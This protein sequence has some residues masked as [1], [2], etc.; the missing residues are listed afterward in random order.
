MYLKLNKT[1]TNT[2]KYQSS[3]THKHTFTD[4]FLN[5][6]YKWH[7]NTFSCIQHH[8]LSTCI[9]V[10]CTYIIMWNKIKTREDDKTN[11]KKCS[12][13]GT[14]APTSACMIWKSRELSLIYSTFTQIHRLAH[15]HFI[16]V[17]IFS[18][19]QFFLDNA[20]LLAQLMQQL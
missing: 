19:Q 3:H 14:N 7:T 10:I 11:V 13:N 5:A 8:R 9:C 18:E 12:L 16:L 1:H 15:T 4:A 17:C 2:F 20:W 6:Y